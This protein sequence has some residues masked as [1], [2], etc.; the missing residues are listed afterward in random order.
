MHVAYQL[1]VWPG[2]SRQLEKIETTS[3]ADDLKRKEIDAATV[4]RRRQGEPGQG[5]L[6]PN[7]SS[8]RSVVKSTSPEEII[9]VTLSPDTSVALM[10]HQRHRPTWKMRREEIQCNRPNATL[11]TSRASLWTPTPTMTPHQP[12]RAHR[13]H[14]TSAHRRRPEVAARREHAA[15][16]LLRRRRNATR[17][18]SCPD[19]PKCRHQLRHEP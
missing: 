12:H 2:Q 14:Q 18:A 16:P 7:V 9:D 19:R 1:S 10:I 4:A 17:D 15:S 5:R 8:A 6:H 11:N 13:R 3:T